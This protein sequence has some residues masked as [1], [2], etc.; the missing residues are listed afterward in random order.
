M[1][2]LH[3]EALKKSRETAGMTQV[4][5][6]KALSLRALSIRDYEMGRL[7]LPVSAAISLAK[8]YKVT[9]DQLLG[10]E[11]FQKNREHQN[12]LAN[13]QSLFTGSGHGIMF[14]DPVL[15]A[16]FEEKEDRIFLEPLFLILAEDLSQK[17]KKECILQITKW[18]FG[19][20]TCDAKI[21]DEEVESI[22]E[23]L[24]SFSMTKKYKDIVRQN[25]QDAL[26]IDRKLFKSI[27]L[28][29][30]VIWILFLFSMANG[31][32]SFEE[33]A[34]IEKLAEK[35]KVNRSNF[36]FIKGKFLKES[37]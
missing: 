16:S 8:L 5:V 33:S 12:V 25:N 20:A 15:R 37:L 31:S 17:Q 21:K 4:E 19:V 2:Q 18:L 35:L 27:G 24:R 10:L 29:H 6:E 3:L 22:Q 13:F 26:E 36:L 23:L 14:L 7:K 28:R 34:F 11:P 32:V 9:L 1:S 30:F